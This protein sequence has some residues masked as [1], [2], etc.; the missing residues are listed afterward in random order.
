MFGQA[1][2]SRCFES[3]LVATGYQAQAS[4]HCFSHTCTGGVLKVTIGAVV[5]TCPTAGGDMDVTPG[6]TGKLTCPSYDSLCKVEA[7]VAAHEA[8][9]S[10]THDRSLSPV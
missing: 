4:I 7:D 9:L 10:L 1:A 5:V 3:T 2:S 8:R 6:Y